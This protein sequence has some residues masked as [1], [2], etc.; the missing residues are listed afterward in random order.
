LL[1][2]SIFYSEIPFEVLKTIIRY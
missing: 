1:Q 2:K